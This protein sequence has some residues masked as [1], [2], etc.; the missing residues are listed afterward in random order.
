MQGGWCCTMFV[1]CASAAVPSGKY[2]A[3]FD[4]G[5]HHEHGVN[6]TLF[7]F[8]GSHGSLIRCVCSFWAY[9]P[10]VRAADLIPTQLSYGDG[11][12]DA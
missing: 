3:D 4:T 10:R 2:A 7:K 11:V 12:C 1:V 6:I 8:S 5:V 9:M